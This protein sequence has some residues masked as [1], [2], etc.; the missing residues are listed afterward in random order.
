MEIMC[1]NNNRAQPFV[2]VEGMTSVSALINGVLSG[3]NSRRIL[4]VMVSYEAEK[5]KRRETAF[6]RAKAAQLG[7]SL[8]VVSAGEIDALADGKTHGG[9]VALCTE[10]PLPPL[11]AENLPE[12]GFFVLLEGIEDPYNFGHT[13]RSLYAAG[14]DGI[15]LGPRNW[16]SAASTVIRSSAGT[17]ELV[18]MY[19][20]DPVHAVNI[21]RSRG[22]RIISAGIRDSVSLYEADLK[23]PLL[24][25]VGGEKRG[26]SRRLLNLTDQ[27][28]RINYGRKFIGSLPASAAAAVI[29]FEIMRQNRRQS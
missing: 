5:N 3:K 14:A 18:E 20:S 28:V 15:V 22:Y 4:G 11:V 24:L 7:Y 27:V 16:M 6:L 29:A 13:V 26:I 25:I 2:V 17:T 8:S 9:I 21:F 19:E 12:A 10:R 1:E 23:L